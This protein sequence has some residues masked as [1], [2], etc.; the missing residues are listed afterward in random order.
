MLLGEKGGMSELVKRLS[1]MR[2]I[3]RR[4]CVMLLS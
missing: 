2:M 3:Y 1:H 4:Q